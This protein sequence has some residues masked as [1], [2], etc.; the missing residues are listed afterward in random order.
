MAYTLYV[1][2]A[3]PVKWPT[4]PSNLL[5]LIGFDCRAVAN[6]SLNVKDAVLMVSAMPKEVQTSPLQ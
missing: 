5:V 1:G 3:F 4:T 2:D 6:M